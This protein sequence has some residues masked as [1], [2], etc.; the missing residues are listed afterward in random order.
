[1]N[2]CFSLCFITYQCEASENMPLCELIVAYIKQKN[3]VSIFLGG[4]RNTI[5]RLE[6]LIQNYP[7]KRLVKVQ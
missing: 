5:T 4:L 2:D 1:M 7:R 3:S 6:V